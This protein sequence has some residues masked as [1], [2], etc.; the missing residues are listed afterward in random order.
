MVKKLLFLALL[1]LVSIPAFAQVEYNSIW[2]GS[3]GQFPDEVCPEWL[4]YNTDSPEPSFEGDTLVLT[5]Q[6][7]SDFLYYGQ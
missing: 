6:E 2:E 7:L 1:L 3:S 5:T 4:Y